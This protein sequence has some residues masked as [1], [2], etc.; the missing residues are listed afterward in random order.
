MLVVTPE[1]ANVEEYLDV[2]K[3]K[4]IAASV[5]G[6][7]RCIVAVNHLEKEAESKE[8]E[9]QYEASKSKISGEK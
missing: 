6:I 3:T 1:Q 7:T 2:I 9:Q 4:A 8:N 5:I